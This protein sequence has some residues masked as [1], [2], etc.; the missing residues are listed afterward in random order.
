[1]YQKS[2][3]PE[4]FA[5]SMVAKV[6]AMAVSIQG[7]AY[8]WTLMGEYYREDDRA[9]K[10]P[11]V[12]ALQVW[13]GVYDLENKLEWDQDKFLVEFSEGGF[14]YQGQFTPGRVVKLTH[15]DGQWVLEAETGTD[16]PSRY[17]RD[18]GIGEYL[19][20]VCKAFPAC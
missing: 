13:G 5:A 1:M 16:A 2:V 15:A 19:P 14:T 8:A 3:V 7:Q 10:D 4:H 12:R 18:L 20:E 17:L 6:G 9:P 11:V